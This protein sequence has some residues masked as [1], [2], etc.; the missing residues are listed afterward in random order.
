MEALPCSTSTTKDL[1]LEGGEGLILIIGTYLGLAIL[2][3]KL[4]F[5]DVIS[6]KNSFRNNNRNDRPARLI[7]LCCVHFYGRCLI[8]LQFFIFSEK[9]RLKIEIK[10]S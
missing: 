6:P 7:A 10:F 3:L 2:D 4:I 9:L 5:M 8:F 1:S